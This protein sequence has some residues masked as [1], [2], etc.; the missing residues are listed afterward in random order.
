MRGEDRQTALNPKQFRRLGSD[1]FIDIST[2]DESD[3][4]IYETIFYKEVPVVNGNM[5]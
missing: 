5:G 1:K 3:S 4:D 2:L